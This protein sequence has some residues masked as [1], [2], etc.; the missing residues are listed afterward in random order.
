MQIFPP[1]ISDYIGNDS[2]MAHYD[3]ENPIYQDEE[4]AEE[5]YE[6]PEELARLLR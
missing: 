6:L 5:D 4:E 2:V 3:F 1:L